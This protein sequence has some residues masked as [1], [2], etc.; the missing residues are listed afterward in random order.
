MEQVDYLLLDEGVITSNGILF[1]DHFYSCPIA[2]KNQLFHP[3]HC[4][5]DK[6]VDVLYEPLMK[7]TILIKLEEWRLCYAYL[8]SEVTTMSKSDV[9]EYHAKIQVLKNNYKHLRKRKIQRIIIGE[10]NSCS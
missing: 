10:D 3:D 2:V 4:M 8:I 6:R 7:E 9:E 1:R 5:E